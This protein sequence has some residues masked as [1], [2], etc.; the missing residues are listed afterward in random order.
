M[1]KFAVYAAKIAIL[2]VML[3]AIGFV[4]WACG[5]E[6]KPEKTGEISYEVVPEEDIPE[7]LQKADP[8]KETPEMLADKLR[9]NDTVTKFF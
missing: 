8:L 6:T 2:L 3:T 7:E 9:G 1:R 5:K 4:F